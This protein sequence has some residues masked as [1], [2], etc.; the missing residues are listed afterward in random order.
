MRTQQNDAKEK[1]YRYHQT[2]RLGTANAPIE[3]PS[4]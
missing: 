3:H 1:T 4:Q 2:E